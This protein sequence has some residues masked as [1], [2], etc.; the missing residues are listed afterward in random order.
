M[1]T[2]QPIGILGG[3]FDPIHLGHI[4]LA[5]EAYK[6]LTLEKIIFIPC[7]QSP[8]KKNK[9]IASPVDRLAMVDLAISN[10]P[11]F[12]SDDREVTKNEISY[13]VETLRSLKKENPHA[14]LCFIMAM[15]AFMHFDLWHKWQ[16]ILQ[17]AHLIV[18]NREGKIVNKMAADLLAE[19][20]TFDIKDLQF[21]PAGRIYMFDMKPCTISATTIRGLLKNNND[22]SAM[23]SPLVLDYIQ[24]YRLYTQL[25]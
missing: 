8:L 22:V 23:I 19:R 20:R 13:T 2:K 16:E 21:C 9:P 11:Y 10:Y 5:Q 18:A 6:Q 15:D 17:L 3:T 4:Q 25:K 12:Y 14:S 24:R 1:S 7:G